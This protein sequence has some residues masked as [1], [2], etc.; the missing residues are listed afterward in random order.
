MI[1]S[2]FL[3]VDIGA[4]FFLMRWAASDAAEEKDED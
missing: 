2:L 4:M 3:L 1:D